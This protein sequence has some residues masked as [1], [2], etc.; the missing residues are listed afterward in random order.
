M[1]ENPSR[2]IRNAL[3]PW[4]SCWMLL[5]PLVHTHP[6]IVH[7]HGAGKHVHPAIVHTVFS[8]DTEGEFGDRGDAERPDVGEHHTALNGSSHE[9]HEP[10]EFGFSVL[11]DSSDRK[12]FKSLSIQP[13]LSSVDIVAAPATRSWADQRGSP[14]ETAT[15]FVTQRPSRAP[16]AQFA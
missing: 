5:I 11:T 4:V 10:T 7:E 3:L 13:A 14:V 16:P 15:L 8:L 9:G 6:D 1:F 2:W 12:S